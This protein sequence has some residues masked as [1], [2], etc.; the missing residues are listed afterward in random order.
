[1]VVTSAPNQH[2][3]FP[4]LGC[5]PPLLDAFTLDLAKAVEKME[6]D[7]TPKAS[8]Q[9]S[10]KDGVPPPVSHIPSTQGSFFSSAAEGS[11]S[12]IGSINIVPKKIFNQPP[13]SAS[14]ADQVDREEATC[15][16]ST[17]SISEKDNA[18]C[19]P[20]I[21]VLGEADRFPSVSVSNFHSSLY[22]ADVSWVTRPEWYHLSQG[23]ARENLPEGFGHWDGKWMWLSLTGA[24]QHAS[25][26]MPMV[27]QSL[28]MIQR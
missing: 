12:S 16:P 25:Q 1:M 20:S 21:S 8:C 23:D 10:S 2:P 5:F 9:Q 27:L 24:H 11:F 17:A 22:D 18:T 26:E 4:L 15:F 28:V 6:Q 7:S 3:S 19:F 13:V 14:W